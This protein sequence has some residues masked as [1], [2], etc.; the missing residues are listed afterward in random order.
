VRDAIAGAAAG[1]EAG[2]A[3]KRLKVP[4]PK[5]RKPK[6]K[7][8][9]RSYAE[10]LAA[11]MYDIRRL[12]IRTIPSTES[13][14]SLI[15]HLP[16]HSGLSVSLTDRDF[17]VIVV[18]LA[19]AADVPAGSRRRRPHQPLHRWCR[20]GPG[21]SPG[22]Q[23]N[24]ERAPP[25]SS[26]HHRHHSTKI[27]AGSSSLSPQTRPSQRGRRMRGSHLAGPLIARLLCVNEIVA[28]QKRRG[29]RGKGEG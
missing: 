21:L 27:I 23:V 7:R 13:W 25:S 8:N 6:K 20:P 26:S 4:V 28:E 2:P 11:A 5:A 17:R 18:V 12:H 22:A 3:A 10:M 19:Q 16:D 9:R 29:C 14:I 24:E 1:G 15:L